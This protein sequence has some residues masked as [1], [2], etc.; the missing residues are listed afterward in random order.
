M[1]R[2][3]KARAEKIAEIIETHELSSGLEI[4][5][6]LIDDVTGLTIVIK[7]NRI[8]YVCE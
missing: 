5:W 3:L 8:L 2:D 4:S 6:E 7:S 1:K